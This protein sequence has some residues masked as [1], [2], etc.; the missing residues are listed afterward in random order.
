ML[1]AERHPKH[2]LVSDWNYDGMEVL[3]VM[4][5]DAGV[6]PSCAASIVFN[7]KGRIFCHSRETLDKY[8]PDRQRDL[9]G[10]LPHRIG[11]EF[12]NK[13]DCEPTKSD[14]EV[15]Q[16]EDGDRYMF[17]NFV[18]PGAHHELLI[19]IDEHDMWIVAADG[20][21]VHPSKAQVSEV[22]VTFVSSTNA[23]RLSTSTWAIGSVCS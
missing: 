19:S 9:H 15:F 16:A 1:A 7:D 11:A 14:L 21:F 22:I 6:E 4:Y 12:T 23:N 5:R 2:T 10:C 18:H 20:D 3:T 17:L 8:D 13:R